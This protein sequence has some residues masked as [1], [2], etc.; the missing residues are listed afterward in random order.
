MYEVYFMPFE[1][2]KNHSVNAHADV[3]WSL[4]K[5]FDVEDLLTF[6]RDTVARDSLVAREFLTPRDVNF[7]IG[8]EFNCYVTNAIFQNCSLAP[9]SYSQRLKQKNNR[10][11]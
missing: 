7:G 1:V 5:A 8:L 9:D 3:L 6:Q 2:L 11:F 10:T 4:L